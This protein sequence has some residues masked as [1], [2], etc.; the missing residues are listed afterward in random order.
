MCREE[1]VL[2][3]RTH[4]VVLPELRTGRVRGL[5]MQEEEEVGKIQGTSGLQAGCLDGWWS[6]W[7]EM[8]GWC[9]WGH[10]RY[11]ILDKLGLSS[12]WEIR[13][14]VLAGNTD[15]EL[16]LG[17]QWHCPSGARGVSREAGH[18]LSDER[19]DWVAEDGELAG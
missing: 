16:Q 17:Q 7:W 19:Q 14:E 5:E 9:V 18:R 15:L 11:S 3:G 13:M 2:G 1:D 8:E 4:R 12:L 10:G 6:H